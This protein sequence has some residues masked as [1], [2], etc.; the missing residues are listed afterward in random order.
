MRQPQH[1]RPG[2]IGDNHGLT[3]LTTALEALEA[4]QQQQ[5]TRATAIQT[6]LTTQVALLMQAVRWGRYQLYSL[7]GLGLLTL[8]LSGLV[9]WQVWPPPEQ[10][11]ARALGALEATLAQQWGSLP[12]PVQDALTRTYGRRGWTSP[13]DRQGARQ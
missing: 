12:K 3:R 7:V 1:G 8:A 6:H 9:R 13:G 4:G 2:V 11:Y 10:G 5:E